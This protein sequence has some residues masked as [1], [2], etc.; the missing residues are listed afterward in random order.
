MPLCIF[1]KMAIYGLM[2][3]SNGT[4]YLFIWFLFIR[5]SG[6][7]LSLTSTQDQFQKIFE[8]KIKKK[9]FPSAIDF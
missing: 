6:L 9:Y 2:V 3:Q 1:G 8:N 4:K 5:S 7:G